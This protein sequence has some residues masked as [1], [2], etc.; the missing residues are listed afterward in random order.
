MSN[1][2]EYFD[3]PLKRQQLTAFKALTDFVNDPNANVFIL[4]GYAGTGKTTLM[5][6]LI[7]W[8]EANEKPFHLLATTGRAAKILADKTGAK[9]STIHSHI[10]FFD[11]LSFFL[12]WIFAGHVTE[13]QV[14]SSAVHKTSDFGFFL[15]S[16][17]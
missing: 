14:P 2:V 7:K 10:Y 5:S 9:T 6:G 12:P 4:K 3:F 8:M 15:I 17:L 16:Y 1:A 13:T 11:S